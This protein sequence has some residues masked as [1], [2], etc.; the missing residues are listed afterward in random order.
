MK[1][2]SPTFPFLQDRTV[3][4]HGP[5]GGHGLREQLRR[6]HQ[7]PIASPC[8]GKSGYSHCPALQI[9]G[10]LIALKVWKKSFD[11]PHI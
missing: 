2:G 6:R 7:A 1:P 11:K 4:I 3:G 8:R 5:G 10:I 9:E